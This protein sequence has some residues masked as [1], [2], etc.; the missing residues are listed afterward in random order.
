[1]NLNFHCALDDAQPD[2]IRLNTLYCNSR[3]GRMPH[4]EACIPRKGE[5]I[6]FPF[7]KNNKTFSFDLEVIDVSYNFFNNT[8]VVELHIA[9]PYRSIAEWSK[10]FK[11][12]RYGSL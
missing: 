4:D 8:I 7:Q 9:S 3:A 11:P 2:V 6:T 5:R 1:M 10:W 12:F